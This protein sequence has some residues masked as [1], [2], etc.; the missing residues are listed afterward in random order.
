MNKGLSAANEST[1]LEIFGKPGE[2]TKE[3]SDPSDLFVK[4]LI[5]GIDVGPFKASG[6]SYA[7]ESLKQIFNQ[8]KNELPEV[9]DAVKTAGVLCIRSRRHNPSKYSNVLS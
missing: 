3:C 7:L 1:M 2:L 8:V 9:Y 5:F 4:K 6:L